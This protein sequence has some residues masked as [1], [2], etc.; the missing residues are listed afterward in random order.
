MIMRSNI[1]LRSYAAF[2]CYAC[3]LNTVIIISRL[4]TRKELCAE[5]ICDYAAIFYLER[6][7]PLLIW[8]LTSFPFYIIWEVLLACAR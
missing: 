6:F 5:N 8:I 1:G 4:C 3:D 2:S 7:V